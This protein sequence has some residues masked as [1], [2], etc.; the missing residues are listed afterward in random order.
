[1]PTP[2]RQRMKTVAR[3]I[4]RSITNSMMTTAR[5]GKSVDEHRDIRVPA[6]ILRQ[7]QRA[8]D[9]EQHAELHDLEVA[10]H[11][12]QAERDQGAT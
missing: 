8:E 1:M 12:A 10:G 4:S 5:T 9:G 2:K 6:Q 11:G 3:S 7:R